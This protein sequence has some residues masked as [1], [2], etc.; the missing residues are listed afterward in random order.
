MSTSKSLFRYRLELL[1]QRKKGTEEVV[2]R[3]DVKEGREG[4]AKDGEADG[5]V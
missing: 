5:S 1:D 3:G 2:C 4:H